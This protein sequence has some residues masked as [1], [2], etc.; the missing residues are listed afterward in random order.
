MGEGSLSQNITGNGNTAVGSTTLISVTTGHTRRHHH[1]GSGNMIVAGSHNISIGHGGV[2][3]ES[4]TIR[5][6]VEGVRSRTFLAGV[7]GAAVT[8]P[9]AIAVVVDSLG[10]LGT[11]SSSARFK[12]DIR[13]MGDATAALGRL[14]PVTFRYMERPISPR[15]RHYGLIAEE[16]NE[17]YPEL[18]A[19]SADGEIETVKYRELPAMLLNEIQK[20]ATRQ[21][22]VEDQLRTEIER[23]AGEIEALKLV[24][25]RLVNDGSARRGRPRGNA[26]K[27]HLVGHGT[28][29]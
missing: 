14:R 9:D 25:K 27:G 28:K 3:D 4:G 2:S 13:N 23:Q 29:S 18:V 24:V 12:E 11:V 1:Y 22:E 10:Q 15:E 6:G 19:R 26:P 8:A 5:I 17:V 7:R 20:M 21:A 16:V